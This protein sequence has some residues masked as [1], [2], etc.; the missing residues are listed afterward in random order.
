MAD[1]VSAARMI[2]DFENNSLTTRVAEL[3][4]TFQGANRTTV[5]TLEKA[6]RKVSN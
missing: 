1:L 2:S 3:E 5:H 6:S 4:E